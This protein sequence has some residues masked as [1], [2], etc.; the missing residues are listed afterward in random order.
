MQEPQ[1]LGETEMKQ[2]GLGKYSFVL[3]TFVVYKKHKTFAQN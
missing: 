2:R 3:P 1:N